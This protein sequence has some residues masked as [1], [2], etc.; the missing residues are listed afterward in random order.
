[1]K[2]FG[3]K[4]EPLEGSKLARVSRMTDSE[5]LSWFNLNIMEVGAQF[6]HWRYHDNPLKEL[7]M[8]MESLTEVWAEI[9]ARQS[10]RDNS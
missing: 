2:I 6:D 3:N 1:M 10:G 9:R 8:A 5:L 4:K 7:D